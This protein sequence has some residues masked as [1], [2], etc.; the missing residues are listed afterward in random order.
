MTQAPP[1]EIQ[2]IVKTHK[3]AIVIQTPLS[4][5]I[6]KVKSGVLSALSQFADSG[7][8]EDVPIINTEDDFELYTMDNSRY[9]ALN[10]SKGVRD[11]KLVTWTTLYIRFRDQNGG[12]RFQYAHWRVWSLVTVLVSVLPVTAFVVG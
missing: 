9:V 2:L 5:T 4:A 7:T 11:Q 12:F 6:Q 3:T 10:A 8:L 1:S